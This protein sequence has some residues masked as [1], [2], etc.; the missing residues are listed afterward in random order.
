V[1]ILGAGF[2][3]T[4]TARLDGSAI[5]T[6]LVS[7]TE[8]DAAVPAALLT[9]PRRFGLDVFDTSNGAIS[10]VTDLTVLESIPLG[11]CNVSGTMTNPAPGGV[12]ID[13]QRGLVLVTETA[14]SQLAAV[15]LNSGASFGSMSFMPTGASPT[16]VALLPSLTPTLGVAVVTNNAASTASIIN[17]DTG[18]KVASDV[19]TGTQPTGVAINP[20]TNLVVIANTGS[21]S[22]T[23]IDL[24]PLTASPVG[25]LTPVSL[26]VDQ[27]PIAVAID[28]DR[29]SNG[30]G[31]AI[32]TALQLNG[33][34]PAT[35][36]L[37]AVDIGA[38]TPV[39]NS[40]ATTSFL[41]AT[42][43]S[44]AFNPAVSTGTANPGLFYAVSS[45]GNVIDTFNPDNGST[46]AIK[47]GVN[48]TSL[49]VNPQTATIVTVNSLS[50]TISLVD[51]QTSQ[52]V[53]TIGIGA[54]GPLAA[55]VSPIRNL[56]VIS[57]QGNNRILLL[58]LP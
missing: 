50:N 45:Q 17:L 39:K 18:A 34:L 8:V 16:G 37:D 47:V 10:N 35:G 27:S 2:T 32:V 41:S 6:T 28:P 30:R 5:P 1:R 56:A 25:T 55:A 44:V 23:T 33:P 52:T 11:Q 13:D 3:A 15:N 49:A 58:P 22:V 29:G 57:D 9:G 54:S 38:A 40:S 26:A 21:N 31:L 43:T 20:E 14:C 19:S 4:T 48:P 36:V 51:A 12:A 7:G 53:E 46:G 42:P 24:T